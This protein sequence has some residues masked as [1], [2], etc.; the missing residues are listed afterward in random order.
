MSVALRLIS[1]DPS[2]FGSAQK[3]GNG[4]GPRNGEGS[5]YKPTILIV[6]DE[7]LIRLAIADFLRDAGYRVLEAA[8]APEAQV[9]IGSGEPIELV[10]SD[11]NMAGP[12]DGVE[13]AEW[14]QQKHPGVKVVLTSG[15]AH[16]A[17]RAGRLPTVAFLT[18]PYEER[19]VLQ[20]FAS[21]LTLSSTAE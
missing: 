16:N 18:K 15:V 8:S 2:S 11:I 3:P 1:N 17:R 5:E 6:E 9:I 20:L 4:H 21:L 10:F 7:T 14:L 12:M 13:L 19:A